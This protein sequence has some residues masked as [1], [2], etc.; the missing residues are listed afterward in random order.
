MWTLVNTFRKADNMSTNTL[1]ARRE[2]RPEDTW[3]A[4]SVFPTLAAWEAEYRQIQAQFP[5]FGE[6]QGRLSEGPALL[7]EALDALFHLSTRVY[8]LGMYAYI[9]LSVDTND[10]EAA[11]LVGRTDTL[12]GQ[13]L[14]AVAFVQPEIKALGKVR[15]EQ[16]TGSDARLGVY[17]QYLD[18]LLRLQEHVCSAEVEKLL[19]LVSDPFATSATVWSLLTDA[20]TRFAPAVSSTGE[21]FPVEQGSIIS[22]LPSQDSKLRQTAWESYQD[23]YLSIKKTLA[24]NLE[25]Y[26]K[27]RIFLARAR[28]FGSALEARLAEDN[29]PLEVYHNVVNTFRKH[30]P[31]W[32]RYWA[33]RRRVLGYDTLHTYDLLFSLTTNQLDVPYKQAVDWISE[34]LQQLGSD[35]VSVLRKG[36]L[37]DRWVDIYPNQGKGAGAFSSGAPAGTLHALV[38]GLADT[39]PGLHRL[40]DVCGRDSLEFSSGPGARAF[41]E[42]SY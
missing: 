23:G 19:G 10:Q 2:L 41:A 24:S 6:Y 9:S 30:V 31:T 11:A 38:P 32:H 29:I 4:A 3:N 21:E 36:C 35:Y 39:A 5:I 20:E 12:H 13:W 27:Q 22:L 14:A 26:I 33:L 8:K 37:E 15:L 25:G 40:Y 1:P 34:G 16:W 18:N 42:D 17:R 7:A 28:G